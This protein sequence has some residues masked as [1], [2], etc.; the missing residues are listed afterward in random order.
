MATLFKVLVGAKDFA[1]RNYFLKDTVYSIDDHSYF[2]EEPNIFLV[3]EKV[4]KK[5]IKKYWINYLKL[6]SNKEIILKILKKWKKR[7][8]KYNSKHKLE[9]FDILKKRI[10]SI[11]KML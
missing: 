1:S 7:I 11:M 10:K 8:K 4:V 5:H 2:P 9:H 3:P 6:S